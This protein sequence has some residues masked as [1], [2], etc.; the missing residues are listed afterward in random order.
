MLGLHL[1]Y[2]IAANKLSDFHMVKMISVYT[3]V[4]ISVLAFGANR[5][6]CPAKEFVH[7]VG[8]IWGFVALKI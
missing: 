1:M 3:F 6:V 4:Y 8:R 5:P 2:L 7:H